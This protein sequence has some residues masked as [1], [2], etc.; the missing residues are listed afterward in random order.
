MGLS[1]LM[2]GFTAY[3]LD[4][5]AGSVFRLRLPITGTC[6]TSGTFEIQLLACDGARWMTASRAICHRHPTETAK[7]II[8]RSFRVTVF[9]P[10]AVP[11]RSGVGVY[12]R[13]RL[14]IPQFSLGN[15]IRRFR[16]HHIIRTTLLGVVVIMNIRLL[17]RAHT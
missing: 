5:G 6:M 8:T 17:G 7:A 1:V 12:G 10:G 16:R 9:P 14:D 11:F 13:S 15:A 3:G 2:F 4:R